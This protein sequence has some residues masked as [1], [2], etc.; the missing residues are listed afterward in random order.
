[1]LIRILPPRRVVSDFR[2]LNIA[3]KF[4]AVTAAILAPRSCHTA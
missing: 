4:A 3:V 1:V 2:K